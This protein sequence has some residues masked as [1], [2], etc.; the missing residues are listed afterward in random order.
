MERKYLIVEDNDLIRQAVVDYFVMRDED[1]VF[2]QASTGLDGVELIKDNQYDLIIL[3]IMLP[4]MSGFDICRQVRKKYN[5]PVFF[6]TA[7]VGEENVI[8]GY[9]IGAD[10]YIQKP[11]SIKELF[12]KAETVVKRYQKNKI[13][14]ILTLGEI[15]IDTF[16]ATT[17]INGKEIEL[18][19]K[20]YSI[21]KFL[22]ENRG[23]V[24]ARSEIIANVWERGFV[25]TDRV[26]DSQIKK[27]RKCMGKS[28]NRI[29]TVF[30]KGYMID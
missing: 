14:N 4:G 8:N 7:L 5:C 11:F 24:Y 17:R 12:A 1:I 2:D 25:G 21:L 28:G 10:D 20:E 23:K 15:E 13:H 6:L 9:N 22:I 27:L 30:G 18:A 16:T 26:V 29:T 19:P 3:D